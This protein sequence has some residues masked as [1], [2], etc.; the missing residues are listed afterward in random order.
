MGKGTG[1]IYPASRKYVSPLRLRFIGCGE[2][3]ILLCQIGF[4]VMAVWIYCRGS[5]DL[6]L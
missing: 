6:L 3:D 1:C 5:W 4:I 2:A